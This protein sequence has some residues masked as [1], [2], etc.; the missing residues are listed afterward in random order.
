M[1]VGV[2]T[3]PHPWMYTQLTVARA[4]AFYAE[5]RERPFF[6]GLIEFMT[7][8]PV[9][10]AVLAKPGAVREW[11]TLIGPTNSFDARV[12]AP[13]RYVRACVRACVRM[14]VRVRAHTPMR[15][16]HPEGAALVGITAGAHK[17]RPRSRKFCGSWG[18]NASA[19]RWNSLLVAAQG[20]L[21]PPTQQNTRARPCSRLCS[22][23][24]L[25]GTDGTRNAVHGSDS[26]TSAAREARFF[27]PRLRV[28]SAGGTCAAGEVDAE[29]AREY[30]AEKLQPTLAKALTALSKAKPSSDKVGV[31][32]YN[33]G[34]DESSHAC[35]PLHPAAFEWGRW[36]TGGL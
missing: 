21:P 30:V 36:S 17:M 19:R 16:Q 2:Q 28:H 20:L 25:Y 26:A 9:V 27:F 34:W 22:L 11:R 5:H 12:K 8:G 29:A 13:K 4:E 3:R 18:H 6:P 33:M 35:A 15:P 24:A 1:S 7:S 14:R 31:L 32:Q 10:A 23:R